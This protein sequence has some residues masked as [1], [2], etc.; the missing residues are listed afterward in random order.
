MLQRRRLLLGRLLLSLRLRLLGL[1]LRRRLLCARLVAYRGS[2]RWWF[3][4]PFDRARRVWT[5]IRAA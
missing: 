2:V 3:L 5:R 4:L 1:L